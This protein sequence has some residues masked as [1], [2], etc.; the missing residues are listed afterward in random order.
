MGA[1]RDVGFWTASISTFAERH[2]AYHFNAGFNECH[3][4]G[5]RGLETADQVAAVACDWLARH[6]RRDSWFLHVHFWD[7]HTPYR[8]PAAFGDELAGYAAPGWITEEVRAEH[9]SLPGPHSA[10][11]VAGFGPRPVWDGWPRQPQQ[12][13]DMRGSRSGVRRLRHR[14][15][16]RRPPRGHGGR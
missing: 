9:W 15:P 5:T 13:P 14:R 1:L 3:N 10:Q 8:T 4:L 2:S 6:G 12:V 16:L 11:E 7:P